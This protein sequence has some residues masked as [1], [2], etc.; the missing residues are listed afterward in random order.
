M[1]EKRK[2]TN[3]NNIYAVI[4]ARSGSKSIKNKNLKLILNKPLIFYSISEALKSKSISKV[5]FLTDSKKYAKIAMGYGAIIPFIRPKSISHD[6]SKDFETFKYFFKWLNKNKED[7][8]KIFVHLRATAPLVQSKDIDKAVKTFLNHKDCD[9]MK[10]VNISKD[11]PFKM[12]RVD[13]DGFLKPVIKLKNLKEP[14]NEPRQKLPKILFQ[15]AQIDI[16]KSKLLYK[17]TISGK[18]IIPFYID[19]YIDIDNK[20]DLIEAEIK[21]Q[22]RNNVNKI[23]INSKNLK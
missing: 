22:L 1:R 13:P 19:N 18:K 4:L 20:F 5:Y 8:P 10:S 11:N 16:F 12:W 15:N 3:G 7:I 6:N 2:L 9:S 21:L 14:W 23:K 17:N